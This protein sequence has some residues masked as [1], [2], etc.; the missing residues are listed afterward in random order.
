VGEKDKSRGSFKAGGAKKKR[1]GEVA[2]L[3][4]ALFSREPDE[5]REPRKNDLIERPQPLTKSP[6][7]QVLRGKVKCPKKNK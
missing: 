5:A 4:G 6:K 1:P 2:Q 7:Q 3:R